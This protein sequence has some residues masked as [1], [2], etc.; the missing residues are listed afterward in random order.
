MSSSVTKSLDQK[1][2]ECCQNIKY[3]TEHYNLIVKLLIQSNCKHL[4]SDCEDGC[5]VDLDKLDPKVVDQLH[6]YIMHK[7]EQYQ[8]EFQSTY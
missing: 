6:N 4:I 2:N 5:V 3:L 1:K 7:M 8:S